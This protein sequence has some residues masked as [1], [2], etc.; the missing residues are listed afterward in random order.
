M[1]VDAR[2]G[3]AQARRSPTRRTRR[4]ARA[5]RA[6]A[7]TPRGSSDTQLLVSAPTRRPRARS[8]R[9]AA[10]MRGRGCDSSRIASIIGAAATRSPAA[11]QSASNAGMK[12]GTRSSPRSSRDHAPPGPLDDHDPVDEARGQAAR[13]LVARDRV[14]RRAEHDPAQIEDHRGKTHR[15]AGYQRALA[16]PRATRYGSVSGVELIAMRAPA[17]ARGAA[18]AARVW[19]RGLRRAA[20]PHAGQPARRAAAGA[21]ARRPAHA[22]RSG[23]KV[24]KYLPN[25]LFDLTDIV[26]MQVRVGPGWALGARAT[27]FVP[28]FIG[29]YNA[30]W[31]GMPGPRNARQDP[32]AR[33]ASTRRAAS[34]ARAAASTAR[35]S[36]AS[37]CTSS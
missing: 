35:P 19:P 1:L 14:Q 30:T 24:L 15:R 31:V 13:A 27:A 10:S 12:S 18:R 29:G 11:R 36:S 21:R 34:L 3:L 8:A 7:A 5:A 23:W 32:P 37:A 6:R 20:R 2:V 33:S 28:L 16:R 26:R 9:I 25:R 17:C 4:T 22:R